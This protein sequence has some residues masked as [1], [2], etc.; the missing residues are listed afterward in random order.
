MNVLIGTPIHEVKDYSMRR[1]LKSVSELDY[2]D[3]RLLM[4]DNSANPEWHL[5]VDEYCKELGFD[6]YDLI[7][8]PNMKDGDDYEPERLG[9][10]REKIRETVLNEGYNYWFSWECDIIC[11]PRI[12]SYLLKFTPEFDAVYH[13]YPARN[14]TIDN[15]EQDGIGCVLYDRWIF[16]NFKFVDNLVPLGADGRLIFEVMRRG[17]KT[18]DIHNKFKLEHLGT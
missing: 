15:G 2:T 10:S 7:H 14:N 5:K 8:L 3:F 11:P 6:N 18:I 9:F 12:L 4:V 16:N 17:Y 13:T 1:W